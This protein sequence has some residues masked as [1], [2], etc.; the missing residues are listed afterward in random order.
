LT[1]RPTVDASGDRTRQLSWRTVEANGLVLRV[2][3]GSFEHERT[4]EA[5]RSLTQTA[6]ILQQ[7][8]KL[9]G[10]RNGD[11]AE[12]VLL[13]EPVDIYADSTAQSED[14]R[15]TFARSTVIRLDASAPA[16]AV[17]RPTVELLV[18]RWLGERSVAVPLFV[19]GLAGIGHH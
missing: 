12:F 14:D 2:A 19:D 4:R 11:P 18:G 9:S 6:T 5:L 3:A 13:D 7:I 17:V 15:E 16:S 8:F 1:T 10:D